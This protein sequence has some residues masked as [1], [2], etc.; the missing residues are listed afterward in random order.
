MSRTRAALLPCRISFLAIVQLYT[1]SVSAVKSRRR[2]PHLF[3]LD[4]PHTVR[5]Q[6]PINLGLHNTEFSCAAES[7][8]SNH[9]ETGSCETHNALGVNCND[10]LGRAISRDSLESSPPPAGRGPGKKSAPV[11]NPVPVVDPMSSYLSSEWW[12]NAPVL[13][14][15]SEGLSGATRFKILETKCAPRPPIL[16]LSSGANHFQHNPIQPGCL[17]WLAELYSFPPKSCQS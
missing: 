12:P 7:P 8:T 6:Q 17:C 10:S 13:D 16:F 5:E 15:Q 14:V 3:R 11:S 2:R 1:R 4:R 9:I